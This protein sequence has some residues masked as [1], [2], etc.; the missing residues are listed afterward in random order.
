MTN[1]TNG[2]NGP[3]VNKVCNYCKIKGDTEFECR[4]KKHDESLKG[5]KVSKEIACMATD[6]GSP[7]IP[8]GKCT[9]CTG[10]GPTMQYCNVCEED[11]LTGNVYLPENEN[12][13]RT[14]T[15][16]T[17]RYKSYVSST[18]DI[19]SPS[20]SPTNDL[21][22]V[23]SLVYG[24]SNL[25]EMQYFEQPEQY[26]DNRMYAMNEFKY[27]NVVKVVNNITHLNF[28][29]TLHNEHRNNYDT[30]IHFTSTRSHVL[31]YR[32]LW[33]FAPIYSKVNTYM[34]TVLPFPK[35]LQWSVGHLLV[36][37]GVVA[38]VMGMAVL[39]VVVM[40][41]L[42][43]L[44]PL[45]VLQPNTSSPCRMHP[46]LSTLLQRLTSTLGLVIVGRQYTSLTTQRVSSTAI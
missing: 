6:M 36:L 1:E 30:R 3:S 8:F 35:I 42:A 5:E 41:V 37:V 28:N 29:A 39:V 16:I 46:G 45:A 9:G 38:I 7:K 26:M 27:D 17:L 13:T 43:L 20:F 23:F 24:I 12:H 31:S 34:I 25:D 10:W 4:K 2:T 15:D 18:L 22:M 11:G 33:L 44:A 14:S 40:M 21:P 19:Y 32:I